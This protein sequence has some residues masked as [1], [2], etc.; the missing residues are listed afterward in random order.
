MSKITTVAQFKETISTLSIQSELFAANI[1]ECGMFALEQAN[2]HNQITPAFD[3]LNAIGKKHSAERVKAWLVHFGKFKIKDKELVFN[4]RRDIQP[5]NVDAILEKANALP[6][7]DLNIEAPV[8]VSFDYLSMLQGMVTKA[9]K[10][11]EKGKEVEEKHVEVLAEVKAL[12]NRLQGVA[13]V[14]NG[15]HAAL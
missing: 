15:D 8:K 14:T 9:E 6:Y 5:E 4:N 7:W 10:A 3:L 12:L 13:P 11:K 1:H 2:V